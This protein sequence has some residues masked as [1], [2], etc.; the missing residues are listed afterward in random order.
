MRRTALPQEEIQEAFQVLC[1]L[2][3]E[4]VAQRVLLE[5]ALSLTTQYDRPIYDMLYLVLARREGVSLI[6]ADERLVNALTPQGFA[7]ILL[8]DWTFP[9]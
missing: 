8:R 5:E 1:Q 4:E 2:G 3:I 9:S 7:L 6:T